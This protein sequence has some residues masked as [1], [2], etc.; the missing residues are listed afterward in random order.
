MNKLT[1]SGYIT[2]F[3]IL[4]FLI[5]TGLGMSPLLRSLYPD[6]KTFK[7][8]GYLFS[9]DF[10]PVKIAEV[11]DL[12]ENE[13]KPF[14]VKLEL[15]S[16]GPKQIKQNIYGILVN[17]SGKYNAYSSVCPHLNC[18]VRWENDK[19]DLQKIWCNCH[20]GA[21]SPADGSVTAGPPPGGLIKFDIEIKDNDIMLNSLTGG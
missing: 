5:F 8:T 17:W 10:E 11:S 14:A 4:F 20:E 3:L 9:A 13:G 15:P 6:A 1:M 12:K 2:I 21:F 19:P 16:T 18:T 7:F